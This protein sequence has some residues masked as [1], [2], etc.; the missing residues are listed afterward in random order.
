VTHDRHARHPEADWLGWL[1]PASQADPLEAI[2]VARP[3]VADAAV[4]GRLGRR[5]RPLA[6]PPR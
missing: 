6:N 2:L 4:I 1:V 3:A 5:P